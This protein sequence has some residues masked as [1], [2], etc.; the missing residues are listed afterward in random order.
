MG[1]NSAANDGVMSYLVGCR[2][3]IPMAPDNR[4]RFKTDVTADTKT[5]VDL[6]GAT[7]R[8][9]DEVSMDQGDAKKLVDGGFADYLD[10]KGNVLTEKNVRATDPS[11]DD[12]ALRGRTKTVPEEERAQPRVDSSPEELAGAEEDKR[13]AHR[14]K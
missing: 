14:R 6:K 3:G 12:E 9:G 10:D 13:P 5:K 8:A 11:A 2:N 1:H 7:H 4:I